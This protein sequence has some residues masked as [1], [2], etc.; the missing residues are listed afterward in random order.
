MVCPHSRDRE[1]GIRRIPRRSLSVVSPVLAIY[2]GN[3]ASNDSSCGFLG[4][5]DVTAVPLDLAALATTGNPQVH[6]PNFGSPLIDAA[7]LSFCLVEDQVFTP[8]P[9][10]GD[11]AGGTAC[12]IRTNEAC[13]S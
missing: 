10:D 8:R 11:G 4:V 12:D 1:F 2:S 7:D 6:V 9:Q 5:E 13:P 3:N